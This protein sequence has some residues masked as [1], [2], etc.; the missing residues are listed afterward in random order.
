MRNEIDGQESF[1]YTNES[2]MECFV[3]GEGLIESKR[4]LRINLSL[5]LKFCVFFRLS[6]L[7][8]AIT[9]YGAIRS[10]GRRET[11]GFQYEYIRGPRK[12]I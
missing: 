6:T 10:D 1:I 11:K 3:S 7:G 9:V 12:T 8:R 2:G 4:E 5:K